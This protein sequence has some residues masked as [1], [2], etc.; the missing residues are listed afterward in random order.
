MVDYCRDAARHVFIK[1]I[2]LKIMNNRIVFL[3][4]SILI[5]ATLLSCQE[6]P[7]G[8]TSTDNT[9]PGK[10][11]NPSVVS[12]PGG[13]RIS[14][15]LPPDNDLLYVKVVYNINGEE[16]TDA[17]T[18][19]NNSVEVMGFGSTDE[20]SVWLTCVDRSGNHSEKVEVK[21]RPDTPP[22]LRIRETMEMFAGFGGVQLLWKN[23]NRVPVAIYLLATDSLGDIQVADVV[24]TNAA[25]GKFNLRGFDDSKR[26]FGALVRDRWNNYSDTLKGVFTPYFEE[27]IPKPF[28]ANALYGDD[29]TAHSS[30]FAFSRMWNGITLDN[31][32]V[33]YPHNMAF[34]YTFTIDLGVTAKLSRFTIWQRQIWSGNVLQYIYHESQNLRKFKVYG[35]A[36]LS[37]SSDNDYW[38]NGWKKDWALLAD[39]EVIKPSGPQEGVTQEDVEAALAGH[40]FDFSM[41]APPVRFI[42]VEIELL[43]TGP[44]LD[45]YNISELSF[46]GQVYE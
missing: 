37:S 36:V 25:N 35:T 6:E 24:Y 23:E 33:H 21:F 43:W 2:K 16:K 15:T 1:K 32:F 17:A 28:R 5:G 18:L 26:L 8:Q 19:Y 20:Q 34:P 31:G 7:V 11:T 38:L 14:Y 4:A 10:I 46:W 9:P 41:D 40:E 39:C 45:A 13:A 30:G 12:L 42:R 29:H 27:E 3:I 22:F 44:P